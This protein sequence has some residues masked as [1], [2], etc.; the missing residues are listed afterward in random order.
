MG[1]ISAFRLL[2]AV[3]VVTAALLVAVIAGAVVGPTNAGDRDWRSRLRIAAAAFGLTVA[4]AV[5]IL[6]VAGLTGGNA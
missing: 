6:G 1:N 2:L 3:W 5:A 4:S